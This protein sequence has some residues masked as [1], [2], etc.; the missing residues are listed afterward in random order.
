MKYLCDL[1]ATSAEHKDWLNKASLSRKKDANVLKAIKNDLFKEYDKYDNRVLVCRSTLPQSKF[2]NK[3]DIFVDFYEHPPKSLKALI[4]NRRHEHGLTEC[5]FC[6]KPVSPGTLDH[7]LPKKSWPEFSILQ[8]N[9][10]PQCRDCAPI[11]GDYYHCN[12]KGHALFISPIFSSLLSSITF[13]IIITFNNKTKEI[14]IDPTLR[15]P[16]HTPNKEKARIISH[17]D[18][19]NIRNRIITY[20]NRQISRWEK[21]LKVADFDISSALQTRIDEKEQ[22]ERC[23]DWKTALY[24]GILK[25]R[26]L[27]S[28]LESMRG[29]NKK[30]VNKPKSTIQLRI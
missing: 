21:M 10:V 29:I 24:K 30:T 26:A 23:K 15:V 4:K 18:S 20:S 9:L 2:L 8:S 27:I 11:K 6:G 16:E 25:N 12:N 5:P 22:S 14:G 17:F 28:Y 3:H 19:L 7:F 13:E 1:K